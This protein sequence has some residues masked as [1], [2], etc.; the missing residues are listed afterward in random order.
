MDLASAVTV[1]LQD[2]NVHCLPSD[3]R[4]SVGWVCSA[5]VIGRASTAKQGFFVLPRLRDGDFTG[6]MVWTPVPLRQ[7]HEGTQIVE[8]VY[9]LIAASTP[10]EAARV[11]Q[12]VIEAVE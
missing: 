11:K 5:L 3:V 12:L 2:S 7:V 8:L 10:A 4:G 1:T 9:I 6:E